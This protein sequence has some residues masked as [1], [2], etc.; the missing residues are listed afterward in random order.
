MQYNDTTNNQGM[1]QAFEFYTELG[2]GNV[3]GN[4]E[5]LQITNGLFNQEYYQLY[6]KVLRSQDDW[7][8]DDINQTD[9]PEATTPLVADQRD[10]TFPGSLKILKIQRADV[11]YDGTNYYKAEPIDS[12]QIEWGI[13]N[14]DKLDD[15]FTKT[16]PK[17]DP[18][19]NSVWLYPRPDAADVSNGAELRIKFIREPLEFDTSA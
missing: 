11:T 5:L 14:D 3:S 19:S 7:E 9:Y 2:L 1:V 15:H 17:F 13:G 6:V 12:A 18:K 8:I 10:Y 4:T 16:A